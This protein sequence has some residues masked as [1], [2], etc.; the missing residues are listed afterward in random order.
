MWHFG[1]PVHPST[2]YAVDRDGTVPDT[3]T[4]HISRYLRSPNPL[5]T[6]N[7]HSQPCTPGRPLFSGQPNHSSASCPLPQSPSFSPR[8]PTTTTSRSSPSTDL[9]LST[10]S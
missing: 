9:K 8:V 3:I 5:H 4:A 7:L 6:T 10:P 1:D 2:G